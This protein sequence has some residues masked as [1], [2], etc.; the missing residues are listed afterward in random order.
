MG[1]YSNLDIEVRQAVK[2]MIELN[3]DSY[4]AELCTKYPS[5]LDYANFAEF[6]PE[7]KA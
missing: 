4:W 5:I 2:E 6:A 1:F 7:V 3:D